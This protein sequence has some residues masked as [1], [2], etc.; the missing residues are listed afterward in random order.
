M[1]TF[2]WP[3]NNP[4]ALSDLEDALNKTLSG[5]FSTS[6]PNHYHQHLT[7]WIHL[8]RA[9]PLLTSC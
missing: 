3:L 6:Y 2:P 5:N 9:R 1:Q 8:T 7:V 4:A